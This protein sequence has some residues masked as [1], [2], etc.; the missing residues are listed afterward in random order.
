MGIATGQAGGPMAKIGPLVGSFA[1]VELAPIH[2][3]QNGISRTLEASNL[4]SQGVAGVPG[5]DPE[6]AIFAENVGHPVTSSLALAKSTQTHIHA[7]GIDYDSAGG[8]N[9]HFAPF[10]WQG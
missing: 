4:V 2:Y 6:Q 9:A 5:A 7:F 10:N 3:G 1:G 8:N